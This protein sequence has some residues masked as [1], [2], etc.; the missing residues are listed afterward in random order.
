MKNKESVYAVSCDKNEKANFF[1]LHEINEV[2][3]QVEWCFS[4]G[5]KEV[6]VKL[7]S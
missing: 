1:F 3:E 2:K 6:V 7:I 5:A 4:C